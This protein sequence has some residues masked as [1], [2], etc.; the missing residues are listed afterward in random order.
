V[1]HNPVRMF[2]L[3]V[4]LLILAVP[5][6]L[7]STPNCVTVQTRHYYARG[8]H[9]GSVL[10]DNI[11]C[12][13]QTTKSITYEVN[14]LPQPLTLQSSGGAVMTVYAIDLSQPDTRLFTLTGNVVTFELPQTQ[15]DVQNRYQLTVEMSRGFKGVVIG[16][17]GQTEVGKILLLETPSAYRRI[18]T[19]A[20][21]N[22]SGELWFETTA[23]PSNTWV[24]VSPITV[25][26]PDGSFM[27]NGWKWVK[28]L[29]AKN[30]AIIFGN[31]WA[32]GG[33]YAIRASF[34]R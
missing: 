6:V 31:E 26:A 16:K 11:L 2:V 21:G 12:L 5:H 34:P 23:I 7:A 33:Y 20:L 30:P 18:L 27:T 3:I 13:S 25:P 29:G 15:P 14:S 1:V 10:R 4:G 32:E 19:V 8:E 24:Y 22:L 9:D 28:P 17:F